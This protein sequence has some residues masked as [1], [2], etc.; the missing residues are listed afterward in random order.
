MAKVALPVTKMQ[1]KIEV[2]CEQYSTTWNED[3]TSANSN[4]MVRLEERAWALQR[5]INCYQFPNTAQI[6]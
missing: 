4:F 6:N 2:L 5:A 3:P 1:Q